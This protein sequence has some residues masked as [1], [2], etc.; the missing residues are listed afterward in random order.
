[1]GNPILRKSFNAGGTI[2]PGLA[3]KFGASSGTVVVAAAGADPVIGITVPQ[4]TPNTGDRVDVILLGIADAV[5]G[6]G[7]TR[8][9]KL[10][11]DAAGKMITAVGTV[12]IVGT[13]LESAVAGD[14]FPVLLS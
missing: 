7:V 9:D 8:G 11:S 2:G 6:A 3:V 10:M 12:T 14:V 1:V 5:A 13:A 4:L